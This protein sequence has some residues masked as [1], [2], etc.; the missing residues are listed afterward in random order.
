M[1]NHA[2]TNADVTS[3]A[4]AISETSKR[5]IDNMRD[6]IWALNPENTTTGDL[7]AAIR[8][9]ASDYLEDFTAELHFHI[10]SN[11]PDFQIRKEC[12]RE[13]LMTVK[14]SLNNIVKHSEAKEINLEISLN[15]NDLIISVSD[16]GRGLPAEKEKSGNGLTNMQVRISSIGGDFRIKSE[17]NKGTSI[18]IMVP[19]IQ[20]AKT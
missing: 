16:N 10:P 8:E 1:V 13:V 11:F 3:N 19:V 2:K 6:L 17:P 9:F 15:D 4:A 14:E 20:L 5:L 18:T 7:I 12:Y